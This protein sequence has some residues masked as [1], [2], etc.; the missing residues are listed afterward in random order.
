MVGHNPHAIPLLVGGF[1]GTLAMH[2]E[3]LGLHSELLGQL[4]WH[5]LVPHSP[6]DLFFLRESTARWLCF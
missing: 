2:S 4:R 6:K 1:G 5:R 3:P